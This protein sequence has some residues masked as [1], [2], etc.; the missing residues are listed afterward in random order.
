MP[1]VPAVHRRAPLAALAALAALTLAA[2]CAADGGGTA[3]RD[4]AA[5]AIA[6]P[7]TALWAGDTVRLTAEPRAADGR[8]VPGQAVTWSSSDSAVAAVGPDGALV[9]RGPGLVTVAAVAGGRRAELQLRVHVADLVY[10]G[11]PDDGAADLW[12]LPLGGAPVRLLPAGTIP[13]DVIADGHAIT[14]VAPSPDGT[15]VAFAVTDYASNTGDVFVVGRDGAGLRRL[16][17]DSEL[18]DQ[19]AWS[20]DGRTLAFRTW[21]G[22]RL[23]EVWTMDADGAHLRNLTPNPLPGVYDNMRPAWSPDGARLAF[24]TQTTTTGQLWTVR[25]DGT[26]RRPLTFGALLD[27]EPAWSPDGRTIAFRRTEGR[28]LDLML[29]DVATGAVRRLALLGAQSQPAWSPDGRLLAYLTQLPGGRPQVATV[30][31][32]GSG[33]TVRTGPAGR[34]A[35]PGW[36]RR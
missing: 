25:A 10:A 5:V 31:P 12:T 30:R 20:P 36:I 6:A 4:V 19:P 24:A 18:D 26:G 22:G 11:A 16:A 1:A 8:P 2:A 14:N 32:D 15:R 9:G 21:R 33:A 17:A 13:G 34:A 3:P 27:A 29:L 28:E 23:G 35:N 7:R